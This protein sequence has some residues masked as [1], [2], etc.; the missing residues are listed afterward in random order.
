VRVVDRLRLDALLR[1]LQL[2]S[3]GR[4]DPATAP[5]VGR[6]V[7]ARRLVLG[8]LTQLPNGQIGIDAR[9]ADIGTGEVRT[10]V[11]AQTR[12][13]D[14]LD[15]EKELAFKIFAELGV[16]LTP[17]ERVA[18]EQRA[19]QNLAAL[20]AYSRG[21]RFEVEGR[22]DAAAEE[23]QNALRLDPSFSLAGSR[24]GSTSAG[25]GGA[26]ARVATA[27]AG[28]V[29]TS[30]VEQIAQPG[31]PADPAFPARTVTIVVTITTP[32]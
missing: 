28:R 3:S 27:A 30:L 31:G 29:N 22:Y 8:T 19:T 7:Q 23:Y 16:T 13:D 2:A 14:I 15:A 26:L 21:V 18:V 32:P 20:L 1:E 6:L 17:A 25:S 5:R 10:A 11:S 12:L 9:V 4:V 24:L